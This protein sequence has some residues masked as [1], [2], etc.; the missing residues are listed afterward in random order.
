MDYRIGEVRMDALLGKES[1]LARIDDV[2]NSDER[3]PSDPTGLRRGREKLRLFW[4]E[5][6]ETLDAIRSNV[7]DADPTHL[8][9]S[10][11]RWADR[12]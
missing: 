5:L 11:G 2:W 8:Q 4:P 9:Q 3:F 6:A 7:L 1:Q 10:M 12:E